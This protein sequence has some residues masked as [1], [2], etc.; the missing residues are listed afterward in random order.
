[1]Q[2]GKIKFFLLLLAYFSFLFSIYCQQNDSL[3]SIV[4]NPVYSCNGCPADT[5]RVNLLITVSE[6]YWRNGNYEKGFIYAR[7]AE[8][9]A[10]N[11]RFPSENKR[12]WEKGMGAAF[13]NMGITCYYKGINPTAKKFYTKALNYQTPHTDFK[14]M[15]RTLGCLGNLE[16]A[17]GNLDLAMENYY[18]SLKISEEIKYLKGM[19]SSHNNLGNFFNFRKEYDKALL[20]F[21]TALNIYQD[22]TNQPERNKRNIATIYNNI[23]LIY[24]D[25]KEYSKSLELQLKSLKLKEESGDISGIYYAHNNIGNLYDQMGDSAFRAGNNKV[26]LEYYKQALQTYHS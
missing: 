20:H 1:M 12:G 7:Q 9:L 26:S 17:T 10:E 22:S 15:A 2:A 25:K 18:K 16:Q 6:N 4:N 19:G 8:I 21:N 14:G 5:Q 24:Y 13:F 11:I 3:L 23:A